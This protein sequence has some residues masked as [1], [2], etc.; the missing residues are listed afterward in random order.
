PNHNCI[1]LYESCS[2]YELDCRSFGPAG[3]QI[4]SLAGYPLRFSIR[5]LLYFNGSEGII[6]Q[7]STMDELKREFSDKAMEDFRLIDQAVAHDDDQAFARLL[8][9]YRRPVYHMIL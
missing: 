8:Q 3:G 2:S 6:Y 5:V 9:R 4:Q 1:V 7:E